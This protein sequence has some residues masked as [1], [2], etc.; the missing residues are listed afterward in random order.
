MKTSFTAHVSK[1]FFDL[2]D[3]KI[4]NQ[5]AAI[6]ET[7]ESK[8]SGFVTVTIGLPKK[9]RTTGY[10]SQNS[11]IMGHCSTIADQLG[12]YSTDEVYH[13]IKRMAVGTF[14]YPTRYNDLEGIEEP[15]PQRYASTAEA[16]LLID[17]CHHFADQH[18]LYLIEYEGKKAV[19]VQNNSILTESPNV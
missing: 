1:M 6:A 12:D 11:H 19:R 9:P 7:S 5:L 8:S 10:R 14:G 17:M 18:G 16:N 4:L 2:S 13:A 15:K 3:I